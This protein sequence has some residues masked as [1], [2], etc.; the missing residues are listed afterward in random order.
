MAGLSL[1]KRESKP[2]SKIDLF[3]KWFINDLS[4]KVFAKRLCFIK[5]WSLL[6]SKGV[7]LKI[8]WKSHF[9]LQRF[10]RSKE[11]GFQTDLKTS[12]KTFWFKRF[13][14]LNKRV[15]QNTLVSKT[16]LKGPTSTWD[17]IW[18][19]PCY[20]LLARGVRSLLV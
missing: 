5:S 9:A 16:D 18:W 7:V 8:L 1:F 14:L 11:E 3:P 20:S 12:I 17:I 19:S 2:S 13:V 15:F 6:V 4:N 10:Y